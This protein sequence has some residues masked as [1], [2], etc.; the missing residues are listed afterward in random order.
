MNPDLRRKI[1]ALGPEITPAML[2]GSRELC[3]AL[4]AAPD[5][6]IAVSRDHYYGPDERHR[7][8]VFRQPDANK[9]PV[10]VFVHGGG[11]VMGDKTS[12]GSPFYDNVGQWAAQQGW[13]G[14]TLT[15][16][17][18]PANRWPSGIEDMAHVV[19]WLRTNVA[20]LGGDPERIVLMG[21]S[22]GASHVGSYISHPDF[23]P[24]G[25]I[26][27]A[28]AIMLS[29]TYDTS[30]CDQNPFHLSYYGEDPAVWA[31]ARMN[32]GLLAASIPMLFGVSELDGIDFLSQA[33]RIVADWAEAERGF[34]P[35][36]QLDGHNHVTPVQLIGSACD[37]LGPLVKRFVEA[38]T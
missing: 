31:T 23:H 15:Y 16:R 3:A 38:R 14:V 29:G 35:V 36:Y 2:D 17:L 8:D 7:L 13:I 20:G 32:P 12:P 4:V 27:I 25:A 1:E 34:G 9:A 24:G 28:G 26:G 37:T 21:Q 6:A 18:A 11:F 33:A 30:N 19:T 22:A 10:L 5:P